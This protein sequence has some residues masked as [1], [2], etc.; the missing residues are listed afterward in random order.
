MKYLSL[1]LI[2]FTASVLT[3]DDRPNFI[4]FI[5]DDVSFNDFG[6]YGHPKIK[7]P[8]VDSLA[9]GGMVF[10]NAYLTTSS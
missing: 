5:A 10:H 8:N 9:Q 1:F 3:A 6:C 7:T 4:M 2:F